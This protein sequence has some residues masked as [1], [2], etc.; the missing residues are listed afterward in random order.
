MSSKLEHISELQK[1][2][3]ELLHSTPP[4]SEAPPPSNTSYTSYYFMQGEDSEEGG[5]SPP[6][7]TPKKSSTPRKG[8]SPRQSP[9]KYGDGRSMAGRGVPPRDPLQ[10]Q[11]RLL[12]SELEEVRR[13]NEA[14]QARLDESGR[15][16]N[17]GVGMEKDSDSTQ[18]PRGSTAQQTSGFAPER[19]QELEREV[20]RLLAELE[21][22]RERSQE[23]REQQ[24]EGFA[25][26]QAQRRE[27]E[28]KIEDL[29]KQLRQAMHVDAATSTDDFTIQILREELEKV[30]DELDEARRTIAGLSGRAQA[31]SDDNHRLRDELARLRESQT[32]EKASLAAS[33][34]PN[35]A[36]TPEKTP[37]KSLA[38]SWT[39]PG[40][41]PGHGLGTGESL[42]VRELKEKHEEMTRLNQ[43]LQ[44]KC[45]EQ[46][47]RSPPQTSSSRPGSGG[48]SS[49]HWQARL[50]EQEQAL[51]SEMLER[52]R[53]L[54]T[55]LRESEARS[56]EREGE[57]RGRETA[58]RKQVGIK[59]ILVTTD[60]RSYSLSSLPSLSGNRSRV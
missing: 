51:R 17:V 15:T 56:M 44:R 57:W 38:D 12:Q 3:E 27:A 10:E 52:E 34:M 28:E 60:P 41:T 58:L 20:D 36:L 37:G 32:A 13:W 40:R 25:S 9:Q 39:T 14:L 11:V 46:L 22:E 2:L 45:R 49:A 54:L 33:S 24:E 16:R 43:E 5:A 6:E 4:P 19:Y 26:L 42:D 31:E 23:E 1:H 47:K 29:H 48:S 21:T 35:L 18:T 30:K 8:G 53:S 7:G 59:N 50:R 55:Q